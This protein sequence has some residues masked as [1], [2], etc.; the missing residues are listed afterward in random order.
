MKTL[1]IV[2]HPSLTAG[3]MSLSSQTLDSI[4]K[5]CYSLTTLLLFCMLT[6]FYIY[7]LCKRNNEKTTFNSSSNNTN[8]AKPKT[9][10]PWTTKKFSKMQGEKKLWNENAK[11]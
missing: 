6:C 11:V 10:S 1:W 5:V 8:V 7:T 4:V 9:Y 2:V 3:V